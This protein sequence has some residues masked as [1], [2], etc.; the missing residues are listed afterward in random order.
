MAGRRRRPALLLTGVMLANAYVWVETN[1]P[2]QRLYA[3]GPSSD[4]VNNLALCQV[5]AAG[6]SPLHT[7]QVGQMHF[8]PFWAVV[9]AVV[10]GWNPERL[11]AIYPFFALVT[12][13]GFALSLFFALRPLTV[14]RSAAPAPPT[15]GAP[16]DEPAW[17]GWERALIALF[18]TLL[19]STALDYA[20]PYRVPWAMT[21]L[22][23]PN[24]ALGLVLFPWVLRSF[25]GI[26]WWRDRI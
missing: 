17:S 25:V 26:R 13:C 15:A 9:T 20:G 16:P 1:W 5:V 4:R 11:L 14:D 23:K 8:E 19:S 21:F 3:L 7:P 12:A 24:H 2:L 6:H 22:L 10:S 18:A